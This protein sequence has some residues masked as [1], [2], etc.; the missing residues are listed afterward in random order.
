M[1]PAVLRR[2]APVPGSTA[3]VGGTTESRT[4]SAAQTT[5][6]PNAPP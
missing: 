4:A 2:V 6:V 1:V 5:S 3:Q